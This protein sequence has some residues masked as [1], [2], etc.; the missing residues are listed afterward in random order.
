MVFNV[1]KRAKR[2]LIVDDDS[3]ILANLSDILG[4]AGY[5]TETASG[6]YVALEKLSAVERLRNSS[7]EV[8]NDFDLC[9]LDFKMPG[10]DGAELLNRIHAKNPHLRAIM[11]TANAGDDGV[12]RA[13]QAGISRVLQKPVDI[14]S[15]LGLIVEVMPH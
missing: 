13:I 8:D 4:E 9:L 11:L 15:L 7:P 3:D 5:R 1:D 12:Q 6:G 10:M 14:P 2:I